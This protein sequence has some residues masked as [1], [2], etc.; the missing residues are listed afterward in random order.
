V[1]AI[2][3]SVALEPVSGEPVP[4][5]IEYIDHVTGAKL[6]GEPVGLGAE[7]FPEG[8]GLSLEHVRMTSHSGTHVDAPAHYGPRSGGERAQT[9]DEVKLERFFANGVLLRCPGGVAD[10]PVQLSDITAE[11]QHI[12]HALTPG[13]IVLIYTGADQRWNTPEYFTNFRGVSREA[14]RFLVE[15][16]G[17]EVIG[18][19]SFGFDPPFDDMLSRYRR[20]PDQDVLW[21]AHF[22]G[23][24]RPYFQ[25]ERLANLS[26]L[27][28]PTGFK[29]ACF[30]L[31]L[32][33]CGA[34]PS[35]VVALLEEP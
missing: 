1:K 30:P 33:R 14:T 32:R 20:T 34:G 29:V 26:A 11:L 28:R 6:L 15:D 23:R 2:D 7:A 19:D 3:L 10:G 13:E 8:L 24:T 35:R 17:I 27:P 9:I 21:P 25:I 12:R 18:V 4:V 31:K 16:C 5:Q 22:Y